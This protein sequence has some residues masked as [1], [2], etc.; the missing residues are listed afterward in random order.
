MIGNV[1]DIVP[2]TVLHNSTNVLRREPSGSNIVDG[3]YFIGEKAKGYAC[4]YLETMGENVNP[5][6]YTQVV[7]ECVAV[8]VA[9]LRGVSL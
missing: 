1:N 6:F 3:V 4:K 7:I 8:E 2:Y 5:V 9:E